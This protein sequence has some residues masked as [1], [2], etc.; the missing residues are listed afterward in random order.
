MMYGA[1]SSEKLRNLKN[2][3]D[4]LYLL[5]KY[6][7]Y[8]FLLANLL[9]GLV[10]IS[11]VTFEINNSLISLAIITFYMYILTISFY[12]IDIFL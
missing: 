9:T 4:L 12:F 1:Y 3:N 5:S 2:N 8:F 11:I 7:L 10:N 6:G